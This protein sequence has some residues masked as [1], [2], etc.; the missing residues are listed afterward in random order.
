METQHEE[1]VVEKVTH[2][3]KDM[4]GIPDNDRPADVTAKPEYEDI[5]PSLHF[6]DEAVEESRL[7][8]APGLGGQVTAGIPAAPFFESEQGR[9]VQDEAAIRDFEEQRALYEK[10]AAPEL[11]TQD[12]FRIEPGRH[13]EKSAA[14]LNAES[15]RREDGG[16]FGP[17]AS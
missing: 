2:Y 5:A 12:A 8:A 1:T 6:D 13:P 7:G 9:P 16:E 10:D 4:L 14:E 3:V 11:S 15:A 17:I